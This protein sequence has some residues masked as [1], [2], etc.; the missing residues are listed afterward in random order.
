MFWY[1]LITTWWANQPWSVSILCQICYVII[2]FTVNSDVVLYTCSMAYFCLYQNTN[3]RLVRDHLTDDGTTTVIPAYN[4]YIT[5][6]LDY[7][8]SLVIGISKCA[9]QRLQ[10]VQNTAMHPWELDAFYSWR[11]DRGLLRVWQLP[12][13]YCSIYIIKCIIY[14]HDWMAGV[15]LSA[16]YP[17]NSIT[18][19]HQI[20]VYASGIKIYWSMTK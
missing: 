9:F 20:L 18:Q 13:T 7:C 8:N 10:S 5:S 11:L 19:T 6:R 15:K 4:A 14:I 17:F 2:R 3:I 1:L 12:L 16:R